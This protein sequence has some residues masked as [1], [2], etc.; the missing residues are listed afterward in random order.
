MNVTM[1]KTGNVSGIITVS[2]VETD[3]QDKVKK[4]L[5]AIGQKHHIDG[6]RAGKVPEGILRKKFGKEVLADVINRETVNALFKYIEDNKLQILGEPLSANESQEVDFSAKEYTFSFEVGFAPEFE[7]KID[8]D[9]TIPYYTIEV[10]DEMLARQDEAF[11][12][13]FGSQEKGEEV[14][15]TALVKGSVV[16]LADGAV[17]EGGIF[18]DSTIVSME[19]LS[20]TD[21][22]AKFL[23]KKVGD[24]VV[25]NPKAAAKDSVAEVASM[26]NIDKEAAEGVDSDFQFEIKEIIVLKLAEKNQEYFDQ[27]FGKDKVHN[28]EEYNNALREMIANQLKLDSNY[29]FTID[30]EKVISEKVGAL[31]LPAE[32]LKKWLVKTNEKMTEEN[33]NEEYDK[34]LPAAQWQLVKEKAVANFGLKVEKEDLEREAKVLAAQQFAQYGMTNVPEEYIEKY[35]EDFLKNEEYR[36]RLIDKAVDDKLFNAI[37]EAV[38]LEEKTVTVDQFNELFK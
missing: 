35:A 20:T 21:E 9:M 6:F 16:E 25:F 17:K 34:M 24:K 26:L 5:K 22:A 30:A 4:D 3:Y 13:R 33:I 38:N 27:V 10:N 37:K 36:R 7:V 19:Y 18:T 11:Q 2:L 23:G 14:D 28:E 8:K 32:F 31:E 12:R 29:R 15:A 1:E